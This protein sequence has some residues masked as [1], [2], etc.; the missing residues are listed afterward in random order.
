MTTAA[1]RYRNFVDAAVE[2]AGSDA[3]SVQVFDDEL[4]GLRLAGWRGFHPVSAAFWELVVPESASS[5]G[6]ALVTGERV[7]VPDVEAEP[8]LAGSEDLHEYRRS[9]LGAVQSTPLVSDDGRVVGMLSTHWRRPYRLSAA[10]L[11]RFDSLA[12]TCASAV[13]GEREPPVPD[14]S[15]TAQ[16]LHEVNQRIR[17]LAADFDSTTADDPPQ[18]YLCEC[19]CGAWVALTG[20]EFD[21]RIAGQHPVTAQGHLVARAQAARQLS[22]TLRGDAAAL[23]AEAMQKRRKS[24]ELARRRPKPPDG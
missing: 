15:A 7:V 3:A 8:A 16:L 21:A 13:P 18:E 14:L 22:Q 23:R 11:R 17:E 1:G 9:G 5:C 4:R 2:I 24:D 10:D 20:S 6:M 12:R 19:G